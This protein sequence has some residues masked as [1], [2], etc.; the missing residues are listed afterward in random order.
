LL[1]LKKK[2]RHRAAKTFVPPSFRT[3]QKQNLG[4]AKD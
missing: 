1:S 3:L 4:A 2:L